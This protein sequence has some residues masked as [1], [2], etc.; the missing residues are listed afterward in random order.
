[1][2]S[3]Y[4]G[5]YAKMLNFFS[6]FVA[7]K[8][9]KNMKHSLTVLERKQNFQMTFS[10]KWILMKETFDKITSHPNTNSSPALTLSDI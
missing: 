4:L 3:C 5:V 10:I 8:M 6:V 9:G 7:E 2:H 1:M